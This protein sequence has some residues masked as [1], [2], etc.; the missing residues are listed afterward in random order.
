M[1]TILSTAGAA[2]GPVDTRVTPEPYKLA[3]LLS[4][5]VGE[6]NSHC[7]QSLSLSLSLKEEFG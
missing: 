4:P 5:T 1:E 6:S 2:S 7:T 3:P